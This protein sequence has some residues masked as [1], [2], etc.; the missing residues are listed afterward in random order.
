MTIDFNVAQSRRI[1]HTFLEEE[2]LS[3]LADENHKKNILEETVKLQQLESS[4]PNGKINER[5]VELGKIQLILEAEKT[6]KSRVIAKFLEKKLLDLKPK[7]L[8]NSGVPETIEE[9]FE[10]TIK[11]E[12][13]IDEY[14]VEQNISIN[15]AEAELFTLTSLISESVKRLE[16]LNTLGQA[17]E[18]EVKIKSINFQQDVF[19]SIF[20]FYGE[21]GFTS[22]TGLISA[23]LDIS[24]IYL[25]GKGRGPEFRSLV[26]TKGYIDGVRGMLTTAIM[27]KNAGLDVYLPDPIDDM[28]RGCDLVT[29]IDGNKVAIS[30]EAKLGQLQEND[31]NPLNSTLSYVTNSEFTNAHY[32]FLE[33]PN[34]Y[35]D[36]SIRRSEFYYEDMKNMGI[37][38]DIATEWFNGVIELAKK[39]ICEPPR[40]IVNDE[41]I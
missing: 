24:E 31:R 34:I 38:S 14:L 33:I 6:P 27:L 2:R 40:A 25:N 39:R 22:F 35:N 19:R 16:K 17:R 23:I 15:E 4:R 7:G 28:S 37:P 29:I 11:I 1:P 10:K 20:Q 3:I 9:L 32:L 12:G 13:D 36:T 8:S 18:S 30:I 5:P 41:P 26:S 21:N